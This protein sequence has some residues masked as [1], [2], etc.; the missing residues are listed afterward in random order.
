MAQSDL[1]RIAEDLATEL[2]QAIGADLR[3]V[4]ALMDRCQGWSNQLLATGARDT[5]ARTA[6][7]DIGMARQEL[8]RT[9]QHLRRAQLVGT[10]WAQNAVT[11]TSQ[12]NPVTG[13]L[14]PGMAEHWRSG[15]NT[16]APAH[17]QHEIDD[18]DPISDDLQ[19][20][21]DKLAPQEQQRWQRVWRKFPKGGTHAQKA[22]FYRAAAE[23]PD[24]PDHMRPV[25]R[26][27]AFNHDVY[28]LFPASEVTINNLAEDGTTARQFRVDALGRR[29]IVSLKYTQLAKIKFKTARGYVDELLKKYAPGRKDLV[30]APTPGNRAKLAERPSAMGKPL[31]GAMV[32]GIP[33]QTEPIP[34]EILDY[35]AENDIEIREITVPEP[36][37]DT[38]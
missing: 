38:P 31:R 10:A 37:S 14:T 29:E 30:V 3:A 5:F 28:P 18:L 17:L 9:V 23:E 12:G 25:L 22:A 13:D 21:I 16:W 32:L 6:A 24:V 35:A 8:L 27:C 1:Q 2:D 33:P 19:E 4:F 7:A 36:G 26:G 20:A 15:G 34:E 11:A